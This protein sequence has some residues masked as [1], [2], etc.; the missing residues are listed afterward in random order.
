[1]FSTETALHKA[2]ISQEL[3]KREPNSFAYKTQR[4][5]FERLVQ[6]LQENSADNQQELAY[7]Q[8]ERAGME[9]G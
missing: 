6:E 1:M 4:E 9:E 3:C 5:S 8:A 7:L 2:Q